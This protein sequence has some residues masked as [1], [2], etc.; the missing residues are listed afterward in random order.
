[1]P[2]DFFNGLGYD[3]SQG[4]FLSED[5]LGIMA[6]PNLYSYVYDYPIGLGDP[7][8]QQAGAAPALAPAPPPVTAPIPPPVVVL[9]AAAEGGALTTGA[10]TVGGASA[11][12]IGVV[13]VGG[14]VI[15]WVAGRG[16]GHIP[17]GSGRTVDNAV[18]D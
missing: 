2:D 3:P 9:A 5:P 18:Q 7:S 13:V 15:G 14:L 17:I 8:G 11:G 16:I 1:M 6:G 12:T 10:A 4:R